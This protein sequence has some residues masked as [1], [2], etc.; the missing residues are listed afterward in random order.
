MNKGEMTD[1]SAAAIA[2]ELGPGDHAAF[3]FRSNAERLALAIPYIV[4]G[5]RNRERCVYIAAENSVSTILDELEREG[6]NVG[7]A[8]SMGGLS[9]V[10]EHHA[11]L[12]QG[13]FD[14]ERMTADLDRD[15]RQ[16]LAEGFAGMRVTGESAWALE[17]HATL[18]RLCDYEQNLCHRWPPQLA[19]LCQYDESRFPAEMVERMIGCHCVV[20]R[21]GNV[22]RHHFHRREVLV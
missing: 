20:I 7:E 17:S 3:F 12:R 5:L 19:A 8:I 15:V 22:L 11:Y 21:G 4:N 16:A 1:R 6:I 18:S 9:V 10:T 2:R 13:F 14:P